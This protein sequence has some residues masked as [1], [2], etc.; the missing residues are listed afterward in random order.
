MGSCTAGSG[1]QRRLRS[2][3]SKNHC[4]RACSR[5]ITSSLDEHAERG[6]PRTRISE[7]MRGYLQC[8]GARL[9]TIID[10]RGVVL[11]WDSV[12]AVM[13][14]FRLEWTKWWIAENTKAKEVGSSRMLMF[15][16]LVGL[17]PHKNGPV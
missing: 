9:A 12:H 2:T 3:L 6:R 17:E 16:K 7:Q 1:A 15:E 13:E 8:L 14:V 4:V 11:A 5:R 10:H